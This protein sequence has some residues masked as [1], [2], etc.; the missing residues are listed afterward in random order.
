MENGTQEVA[1]LTTLDVKPPEDDCT[2]LS[3][4]GVGLLISAAVADAVVSGSKT[5]IAV[6]VDN[7]VIVF[8]RLI[9]WSS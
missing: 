2:V 4:T 6:I 1:L 3:P 7:S 9:A 5:S 8:S